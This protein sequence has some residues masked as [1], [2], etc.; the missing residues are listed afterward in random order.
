MVLAM[1]Q[2]K[3][4]EQPEHRREHGVLAGDADRGQVNHSQGFG[5]YSRAVDAVEVSLWERDGVRCMSW[6][7]CLVP[8]RRLR[9]Q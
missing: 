4:T 9:G 8:M 2:K 7:A 1:G 5:L 6:E 3:G